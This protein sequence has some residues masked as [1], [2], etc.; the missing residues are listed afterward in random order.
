MGLELRKGSW[1]KD[2][3]LGI[4]SV[5]VEVQAM[6]GLDYPEGDCRKR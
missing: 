5:Y 3:N 1:V 6:L 2:T 4:V